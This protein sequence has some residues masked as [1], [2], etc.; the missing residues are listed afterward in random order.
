MST[1]K[2]GQRPRELLEGMIEISQVKS[3][4]KTRCRCT[5]MGLVNFKQ[6]AKYACSSETTAKNDRYLTNFQQIY[7]YLNI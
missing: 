2:C 6:W 5:T 3:T 1:R 4:I 7:M